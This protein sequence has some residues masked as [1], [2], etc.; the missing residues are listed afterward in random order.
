MNSF[1]IKELRR[2]LQL[3]QNRLAAELGVTLATVG[4]WECGLREPS[5][6]AVRAMKL[7]LDVNRLEKMLSHKKGVRNGHI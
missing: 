1:E 4:R 7:L 2:K 3:S 6:L 5:N